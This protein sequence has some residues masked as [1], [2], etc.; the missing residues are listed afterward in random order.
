MRAAMGAVL[1]ESS[2]LDGIAVAQNQSFHKEIASPSIFTTGIG[3][4]IA[5]FSYWH[6]IC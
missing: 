2:C 1:T 5:V 4:W 6:D 3:Q